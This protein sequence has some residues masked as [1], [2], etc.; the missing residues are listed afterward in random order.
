[1][2]DTDQ[3]LRERAKVIKEELDSGEVEIHRLKEMLSSMGKEASQ[4]SQKRLDLIKEYVRI[5][6]TL[7]EEVD[8]FGDEQDAL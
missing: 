4:L 2:S 5:K 1:M 7:K 6:Q 3:E 8:I